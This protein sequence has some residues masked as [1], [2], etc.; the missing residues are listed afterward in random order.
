MVDLLSIPVI[1]AREGFWY[2]VLHSISALII[3]DPNDRE[4]R[5]LRNQLLLYQI[6]EF[7]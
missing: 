2:D 3:V 4:L 1:H 5:E 7:L 6:I